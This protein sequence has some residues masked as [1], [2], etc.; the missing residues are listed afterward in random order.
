MVL[1]M[2]FKRSLL[3]GVSGLKP[4]KSLTSRF[5]QEVCS[6]IFKPNSEKNQDKTLKKSRVKSI[7]PSDKKILS[8]RLNFQRFKQ[9]QEPRSKYSKV[10]RNLQSKNK[11]DNSMKNN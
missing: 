6:R 3:V 4:V 8:E 1:R 10:N 5:L 7:T 9:K 2:K 11:R